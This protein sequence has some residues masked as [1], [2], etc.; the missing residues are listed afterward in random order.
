[1]TLTV[2]ASDIQSAVKRVRLTSKGGV[3]PVLLTVDDDEVTLTADNL[4]ARVQVQIPTLAGDLEPVLFPY[5]D[6]ANVLATY[7]A[8]PVEVDTQGSEL[9][10]KGG[11]A[12]SKLFTLNPEAFPRRP[13]FGESQTLDLTDIWGTVRRVA[14]AADTSVADW[15]R[16]LFFHGGF[17]YATDKYRVHRCSVPSLPDHTMRLPGPVV[18]AV[19]A[20]KTPILTLR[21]SE[22]HF[23]L[24]AADAVWTGALGNPEEVLRVAPTIAKPFENELVAGFTADRKELIQAITAAGR[25]RIDQGTFHEVVGLFPDEEGL[26]VARR[27]A[28]VG[29]HAQS[30]PY[31]PSGNLN[32]V[33]FNATNLLDTLKLLECEKVT[34][35]GAENPRAPWRT[36]DEHLQVAMMPVQVA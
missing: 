19:I 21:W 34:L 6:V 4:D 18:N 27:A 5:T 20:A 23:Q 14:S 11:R 22:R 15:V 12:R 36:G 17:V 31:D 28:D 2:E 33:G 29:E 35:Q 13:P 1:M 3:C 30:I 7:P 26:T 16:D 9:R 8:G 25:L 10:F 24:V 32:P